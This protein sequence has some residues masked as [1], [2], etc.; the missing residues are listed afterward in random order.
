MK[1]NSVSRPTAFR[2]LSEMKDKGMA[3]VKGKGRASR[4]ELR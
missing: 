2:E 3:S 4:Y 1:M